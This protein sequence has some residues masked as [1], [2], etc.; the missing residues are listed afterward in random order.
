VVEPWLHTRCRKWYP[1]YLENLEWEDLAA[2][3]V[4]REFGVGQLY[5][6]FGKSVLGL[7]ILVLLTARQKGTP[8]EES[9]AAVL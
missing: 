6:L 3:G 8:T 5:A 7:A 2:G 9:F 1:A 4:L